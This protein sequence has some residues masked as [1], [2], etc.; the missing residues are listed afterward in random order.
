MSEFKLQGKPFET[1]STVQI[2][3]FRK[4]VE[5]YNADFSKG[6]EFKIDKLKQAKA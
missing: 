5:K 2:Q 4:A 3:Q 1:K 6:V